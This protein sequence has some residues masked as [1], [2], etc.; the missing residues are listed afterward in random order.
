MPRQTLG[1]TTLS[2]SLY[3]YPRS[4]PHDHWTPTC[5]RL[6][7]DRPCITVVQSRNTLLRQAADAA[8]CPVSIELYLCTGTGT[9]S[10]LPSSSPPVLQTKHSDR[11]T[12][13]CFSIVTGNRK[14]GK[15]IER[16]VTKMKLQ[17]YTN[18]YEQN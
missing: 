12:D 13:K 5:P 7:S 18:I 2:S 17:K 9:H 3:S 14:T 15:W 6:A 8:F 11:T 16:Q 10:N 1:T 4:T